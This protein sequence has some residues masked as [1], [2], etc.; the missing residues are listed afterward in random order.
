MPGDG[1]VPF[2]LDPEAVLAAATDLRSDELSLILTSL[3]V[4]FGFAVIFFSRWLFRDYEVKSVMV[5]VR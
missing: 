4:P 3:A 1:E 2:T 5:Q